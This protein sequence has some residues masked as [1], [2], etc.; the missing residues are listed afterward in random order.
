MR[1]ERSRRR[2]KRE[3]I[4]PRRLK[5]YVRRNPHG[6]FNLLVNNDRQRESPLP[7]PQ[8][9]LA[10]IGGYNET[11]SVVAVCINNQDRSSF[12]V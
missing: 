4:A 11:L 9:Q 2:S 6:Q 1:R 12:A 8:T 5:R 7:V 10:Y 3:L